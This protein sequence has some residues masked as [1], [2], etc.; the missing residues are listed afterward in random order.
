MADL[1]LPDATVIT[2]AAGWLGRALVHHLASDIGTYSRPGLVRA[3]VLDH[4]EAAAVH[5]VNSGVETVIGSVTDAASLDTLFAGLPTSTDV[6]HTAGVIHPAK[7]SDF[8][9][10]NAAGTANVAVAARRAGVRRFVHVS[11]NSPFGTNPSHTDTFRAHEPYNPY[12][13]YGESKMQGELAVLEQ[14]SAGLDAV[15]VRPPWFYGPL[16]PPRQTTFFRLVRRGKF[17]RFGSGNQRRSMVFVDNLVNGIVRAELV[18]G[19]PGRGYWIADA[20]AYTV[21]EIIETVGR[22]LTDEGYEVKQG[23][24]SLPVIAARMAEKADRIIQR[25]GRYQ[26]Q[27]HVMGEMAH[28]IACDISAAQ[29]ELGYDPQFELYDG[30]RASIQWCRREGLEL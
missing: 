3:L 24:M 12:L 11:S 16:Q 28:S 15:I 14:V 13:G 6:I 9:A 27:L 22:A 18:S 29:D 26:Q 20:R 5:A 30:M 23:A 7:V 4:A 21:N 8:F 19:V 2:G 1:A 10:I 25:T 17:P